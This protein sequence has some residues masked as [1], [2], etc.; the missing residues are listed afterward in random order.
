MFFDGSFPKRFN[1]LVVVS[2][3]SKGLLDKEKIKQDVSALEA[4]CPNQNAST[5]SK[6]IDADMEFKRCTEEELRET[7]FSTDLKQATK[8][9]NY[10]S[11]M[12]K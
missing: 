1:F 4:N 2:S 9:R 7:A 6:L 3:E 8:D 12:K 11:F 5:Y 10:R